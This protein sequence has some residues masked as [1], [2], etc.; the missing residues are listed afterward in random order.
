M[1]RPFLVA[2]ALLAAA[3]A[4]AALAARGPKTLVL[5]LA[6][7]PAETRAGTAYGINGPQASTYTASFEIHPG[8]LERE[9]DVTV[10][11]WVAKDAAGAKAIY[12]SNVASYTGKG[13]KLGGQPGIFAGE[14]FLRLP[15]YGDEQLADYLPKKTRPHGQLIV[16]K[17]SVVWYLVVEN[18]TPLSFSCYGTSRTE[19]P[20]GLATATAEL[21]RYG[22]K[23]KGRV[24]NG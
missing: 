22:A 10:E 19:A 12:Q 17:G 13:P 24:G 7:F 4:S 3:G 1:T 11:V 9:E 2:F 5:Q 15:S 16:R 6:D 8:D 23:Q 20:I 18:C 21:K 14:T